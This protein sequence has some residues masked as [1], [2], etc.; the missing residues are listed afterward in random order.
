MRMRSGSKRIVNGGLLRTSSH[1]SKTDRRRIF[2]RGGGVAHVTCHVL[3]LSKVKMSRS[4]GRV[5]Y[6]H[7]QRCKSAMDSRINF[8]LDGND[9][10]GWLNMWHAF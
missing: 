1:K 10:R 2:K 9:Q 8:K 5:T 6:P 4:Q 7:Q 3:P